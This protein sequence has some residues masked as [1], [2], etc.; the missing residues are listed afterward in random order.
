MVAVP[1][2]TPVTIP[3]LPTVALALLLLHVPPPGPVSGKLAPSHTAELP[4]MAPTAAFT[5]TT[6]LTTQPVPNE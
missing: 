6:L 2:V 1:A 3:V 4:V 5:V